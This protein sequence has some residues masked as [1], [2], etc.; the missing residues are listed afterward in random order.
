MSSVK[1]FKKCISHAK[2][3]P[4]LVRAVIAHLFSS[5]WLRGPWEEVKALQRPLRDEA[6]K[7]VMRGED[8]ED[9][10]AV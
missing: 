9:K 2:C 6:V 1:I 8:K 3:G 10:L 4:F 5:V 7:I